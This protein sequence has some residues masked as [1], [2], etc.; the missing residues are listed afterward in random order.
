MTPNQELLYYCLTRH[1]K[2]ISMSTSNKHQKQTKNRVENLPPAIFSEPQML[3]CIEFSRTIGGQ[4]DGFSFTEIF[5]SQ[6]ANLTLLGEPREPR[7]PCRSRHKG[8]EAVSFRLHD[9][10]GLV[11]ILAGGKTGGTT[12]GTTG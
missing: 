10:M 8:A 9:A 7:P 2:I 5:Q 1:S 11:T 3:P 6:T 4:M 12:G